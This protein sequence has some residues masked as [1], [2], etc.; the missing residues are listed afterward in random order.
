MRWGQREVYRGEERQ[1]NALLACL[2]TPKIFHKSARQIL[3]N[4]EFNISIYKNVLK[5][6]SPS[7]PVFKVL[8]W[9]ALFVFT[10]CQRNLHLKDCFANF[11]KKELCKI[12]R[13]IF[14]LIECL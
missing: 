2:L 13:I 5:P 6:V 3:G 12:D 10:E 4:R 14:T 11:E 9:P 8:Y 1:K 7:G